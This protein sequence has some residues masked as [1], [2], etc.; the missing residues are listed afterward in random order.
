MEVF[1]LYSE[2]IFH[3]VTADIYLDFFWNN[4]LFLSICTHQDLPCKS[5]PL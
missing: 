5:H 1:R 3:I 4:D 2:D